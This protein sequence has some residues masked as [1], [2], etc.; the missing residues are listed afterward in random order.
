MTA[1]TAGA[2]G[3]CADGPPNSHGGARPSPG[4]SRRTSP[5]RI[6]KVLEI[7]EEEQKLLDDCV[8]PPPKHYLAGDHVHF[9]TR[10]KKYIAA[11]PLI[12]AR[13]KG[14]AMVFAER[15]GQ[16]TGETTYF[17]YADIADMIASPRPNKQPTVH[18]RTAISYVA[19]LEA[20]GLME[21]HPRWPV[22]QR[23]PSWPQNWH[24]CFRLRFPPHA[25]P[26]RA[27]ARDDEDSDIDDQRRADR[28]AIEAE[29]AGHAPAREDLDDVAPVAEVAVAPARELDF[30]EKALLSIQ[31]SSASKPP[32][33]S[34]PA[35]PS[36][37]KPPVQPARPTSSLQPLGNW[38]PAQ[39]KDSTAA[40]PSEHEAAVTAARLRSM[41][42]GIAE[43]LALYATA[44]ST[45]PRTFV[46][47]TS[48]TA[49]REDLSLMTVLIGIEQSLRKP[50]RRGQALSDFVGR[51]ITHVKGDNTASLAGKKI[52]RRIDAALEDPLSAL[53]PSPQGRGPTLALAR[54]QRARQ[55]L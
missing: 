27:V 48:E 39:A 45:L 10:L 30:F 5:R 28:D 7:T 4:A 37:V 55:L 44:F 46:R 31:R 23:D 20:L 1:S 50:G 38:R 14:V 43:I 6:P 11:S 18:R 35:S 13:L 29:A 34:S 51:C 32:T 53:R 12:P 49:L 16:E 22:L 47:T 2:G 9:I 52:V 21:T 3:S 17:S 36:F 26:H 40:A 41:E 24:N 42:Q 54:A 33:A 19:D 8:N 15:V 25:P